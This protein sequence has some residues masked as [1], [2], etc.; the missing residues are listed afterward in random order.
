MKNK[1]NMQ[2]DVVDLAYQII[3]MDRTITAQAAELERLRGVEE[4]YNELLSS[5][6]KHGQHMMHNLLDV[7]MTPGVADAFV[8]APRESLGEKG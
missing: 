6:L 5:S 7:L 2:I 1:Q 8:N 3:G 4:R